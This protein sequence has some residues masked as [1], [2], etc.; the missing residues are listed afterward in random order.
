MPALRAYTDFSLCIVV[1][2]ADDIAYGAL[3]SFDCCCSINISLLTESVRLPTEGRGLVPWAKSAKGEE[4]KR[5]RSEGTQPLLVRRN[6]LIL[7]RSRDKI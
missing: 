7:N 1:R 3:G 2:G 5:Q 6:L 4:V